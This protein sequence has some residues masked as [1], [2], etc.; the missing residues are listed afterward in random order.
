MI[1]M[2]IYIIT[3]IVECFRSLLQSLLVP[4]MKEKL[5]NLQKD[6]VELHKIIN[7]LNIDDRTYEND[8]IDMSVKGTKHLTDTLTHAIKLYRKNKIDAHKER[9]EFVKEYTD[10]AK[11]IKDAIQ[12]NE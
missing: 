11:H 12:D 9:L 5:K 10:V 2:I 4:D 1:N 6:N 3:F 7:E 8:C